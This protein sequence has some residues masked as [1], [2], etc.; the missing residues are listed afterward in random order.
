MDQCQLALALSPFQQ[1][2]RFWRLLTGIH[3]RDIGV[4][5][6]AGNQGYK[7]GYPTRPHIGLSVGVE[8]AK[9]RPAQAFRPQFS[10]A[11]LPR[12]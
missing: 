9:P 7:I 12:P 3:T 6:A 8:D 2:V 11:E 5:G 4:N 10:G 1:T